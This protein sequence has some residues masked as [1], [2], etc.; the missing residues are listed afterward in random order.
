MRRSR[1]GRPFALVAML[2]ATLLFVADS[3]SAAV[4]LPGVISDHMV[5]QQGM[6]VP[7]W[8]TADKGETVTV[9]FR[10]QTKTATADDQ[11]KWSVK[12][13]PLA[14]GGP[15]TLTIAASNTITINDVLVGEVW[16]GSGQSN[17]AGPTN[18]YKDNDPVL[19]E[20]ASVDRPQLRLL[21]GNGTWQ[22]ATPANAGQF[23]AIQY[24]FGVR[25]QEQTKQP[26]GLMVGAVGGT[27]SGYWLTQEMLDADSGCREQWLAYDRDNPLE[28]RQ[29]RLDALLTGYEKALAAAKESGKN[30]PRKPL[31]DPAG[32][33]SN[34]VIGHLYKAHIQPMVP[35]GIRGVLWDQGE[36][37]TA[38][39]GVDQFN[40]MHALILG[41]RK[42]WGQ[43]DFPFLYVQ[44]PSGN[45]CV[46]DKENPVTAQGQAFTALPATVPADG[47]YRETHIRIMQHPHTAMVISSD[48][49]AGI[50]PANK[51][52]YGTR[53]AQVARGFVY[54]EK[55]EYYGPLFESQVIDGSK[56]RIRFTHIGQG[57]THRHGDKLQ[58][59]AIAGEDKKFV[60]GDATIEGD[61][62]VVSAAAV[63]KP[64][65]V[66]YAWS[67]NH[68]W[69]NLFNKDGLPAIPFRTDRW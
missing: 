3:A 44:K 39:G 22:V 15:E 49:G 38:I 63:S 6:N 68:T 4:K 5:L 10:N 61:T 69:A 12:L 23:S 60:W 45:G 18:G 17:M 40:A 58:G 56:V 46:W 33:Q 29:K 16:V 67:Q 11:G 2:S 43:G 24:A 36:S 42:A 19:K 59:F 51:S 55:I 34:G 35:Y 21:K 7:L 66:R 31:L 62:V 28:A 27:P 25:L 13:E 64:V 57:I 54:G 8:G 47:A 65:A 52:G 37:G 53:A 30:P 9:K 14:V 1:F 32:G 26:V 50:H 41:W 48:L 20:L